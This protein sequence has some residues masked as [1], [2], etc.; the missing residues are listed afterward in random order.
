[1]RTR[2]DHIMPG[3]LLLLIAM[4]GCQPLL[5]ARQITVKQLQSILASTQ[6]ISDQRVASQIEGLELTERLS[7]A[8]FSQCMANL[9][10][11]R[12][13]QAF[14][15]LSDMSAFLDPSAT[16]I[17]ALPEPGLATQRKMMTLTADYVTKTM[18]HL[19]NF[20]ARRVT[21]SFA[22]DLSRHTNLH[23]VGTYEAAVTYRDGEEKQNVTHSR[24]LLQGLTTSG[25]FGPILGTALI[26]AAVGNLA[27]SH[28]EQGEQGAE[29]VF[30]YAVTTNESHFIVENQPTAYNGE[31]AIDPS[32]GAIRRLVLLADL[33]PGSE[34][35]R[36]DIVVEYG[37]VE[38]G[39]TSYIC[40]V[41]GVAISQ[42]RQLQWLNDVVFDQ[43]H[44]FRSNVQIL[45]GLSEV[46]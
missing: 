24:Q 27:W 20:Y 6:G 43:Y 35:V 17:P 9:P 37:P 19:P 21:A 7:P 18:H 1:M 3:L 28:W 39:G 15:V 16:E 22:S 44:L 32:D 2:S 41:K 12:S 25:E 36:A 4:A 40:P 34:F 11:P 42:V 14:L 26:D 46:H 30:R 33:E 5:A 29:A 8:N 38:I 45:P 23:H 31:I 10:G 13:K